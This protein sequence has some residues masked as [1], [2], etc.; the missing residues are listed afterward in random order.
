M[1]TSS[2]YIMIVHHGT[3]CS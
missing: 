2:D 1:A 3:E